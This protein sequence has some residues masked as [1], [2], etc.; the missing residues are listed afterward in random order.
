MVASVFTLS[1]P[2]LKVRKACYDNFGKI[3]RPYFF[4]PTLFLKKKKKKPQNLISNFMIILYQ[5]TTRYMS[6]KWVKHFSPKDIDPKEEVAEKT[7]KNKTDSSQW[8]H[9]S[10]ERQKSTPAKQNS[11]MTLHLPC[12][13]LW[14][15][16]EMHKTPFNLLKILLI[17]FLFGTPYFF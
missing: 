2:I 5:N 15:K 6:Y 10:R 14:N 17:S 7:E 12:P 13:F 1:M 9:C 3:F 4:F 11:E 16:N 8:W